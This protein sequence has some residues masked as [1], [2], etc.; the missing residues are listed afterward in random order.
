MESMK[1]WKIEI[2]C[3]PFNQTE[4]KQLLP[5]MEKIGGQEPDP[6]QH[7]SYVD[8]HVFR[9]ISCN[10]FP[11]QYFGPYSHSFYHSYIH[12]HFLL[13]TASLLIGHHPEIQ[14]KILAQ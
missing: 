5:W 13:D 6:T 4:I 3:H 14:T 7:K 11:S 1:T 8:F 12:S 2:V 9:K 10:Q